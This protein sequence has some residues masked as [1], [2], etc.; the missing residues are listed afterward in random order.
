MLWW[1]RREQIYGS[2]REA[3]G[4]IRRVTSRGA[5]CVDILIMIDDDYRIE[6]W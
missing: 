5:K 1:K 3:V 6:M 2:D 4:R